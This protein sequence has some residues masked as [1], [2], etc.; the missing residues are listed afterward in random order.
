MGITILVSYLWANHEML[1]FIS[2]IS[3]FSRINIDNKLKTNSRSLIKIFI[4]EKIIIS[5]I[6]SRSIDIHTDFLW[7]TKDDITTIPISPVSLHAS[8]I[9]LQTYQ[10]LNEPFFFRSYSVLPWVQYGRSCLTGIW[11]PLTLMRWF[12]WAAPQGFQR[13]KSWSRNSFMER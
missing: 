5:N 7:G 1:T 6:S 13:Y 4:M 2:W 3:H 11:N 12:W 9:K 10:L 8:S